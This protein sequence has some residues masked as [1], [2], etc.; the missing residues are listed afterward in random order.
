M[1]KFEEVEQFHG[2]NG[3]DVDI[4]TK[5]SLDNSGS[6]ETLQNALA[7]IVQLWRIF[8]IF[9]MFQ[10]FQKFELLCFSSKL[11]EICDGG[12]IEQRTA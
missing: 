8:E 12:K 1:R 4:Y 2:P 6:N 9:F 7:S 11:G 3:A 5:N 10:E